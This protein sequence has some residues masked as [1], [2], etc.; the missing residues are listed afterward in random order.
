MDAQPL[1][2]KAVEGHDDRIK[3]LSIPFGGPI[4]QK[5]WSGEYFSQRTNLHP[6]LFPGDR[7]MLYDH[8]VDP[9]IKN[10]II[11]RTDAKTIEQ[12]DLG[13]WVEAQ[14]DRHSKY[15]KALKALIDKQ[16]L[17]G[18][19]GAPKALVRKAADGEILDW[20]WYEQ[21]LTPIPCNI[22]SLVEPAIARKHYEAAGL[23]FPSLGSEGGR[24]P[25]TAAAIARAREVAAR[26]DAVLTIKAAPSDGYNV[27]DNSLG[28]APHEFAYVDAKGRGHLPVH[29]AAHVRAALARFKQTQIPE[30]AK[31]GAWKKLLAAAKKFGIDVSDTTMPK[32]VVGF[33]TKAGQVLSKSNA[34]RL[35][36]AHDHLAAMG[37]S[38]GMAMCDPPR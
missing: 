32:H 19:T 1:Q 7:P 5:D 4:A 9:L 31:P 22:Y 14:L 3:I 6:E 8:G 23:A 27:H 28:A 36:Q 37:K 16:S 38:A 13:W 20:P 33:D 35:Q 29:D 12:D 15:F 11:G 24:L 26:L 17:Y 18:S 25:E 30:S 2:I 34:D 21:T 10:E